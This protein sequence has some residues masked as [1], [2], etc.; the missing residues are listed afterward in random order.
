LKGEVSVLAREI[1]IINGEGEDVG[2][3]NTGEM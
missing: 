2:E 3:D 1:L